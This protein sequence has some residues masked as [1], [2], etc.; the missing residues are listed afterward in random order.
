MVDTLSLP[1]GPE[2]LGTPTASLFTNVINLENFTL[3][4]TDPHPSI[5]HF[6]FSNLTT[7]NISAYPLDDEFHVSQLL[8]FLE[9][10]PAVQWVDMTF[11]S[12]SFHEDVPAERVI[13]L[14]RVETFRL[15][16]TSYG[17][18]QEIAAHIS[19]PSARHVNFD[20]SL[21][22]A[23]VPVPRNIYPSPDA[24]QAIVCQYTKARANQVILETTV[25]EHPEL[26]CLLTFRSPNKS[27]LRL[28]YNQFAIENEDDL[29]WVLD[30][31]LPHVFS[32]ASRV[33]R[34]Y[35]FLSRIEYLSI[36]GGKLTISHLGRA[37]QDVGNLLESMGRLKR[38]TL[39]GC[40]L[41]P[42]LDPFLDTPL[43]SD[44]I[45]SAS[46]PPIE[47]LVIINPT[48]SLCDD[49]ACTTAIVRLARSQRARGI[50]F[51]H[52]VLPPGIPSDVAE[53]LKKCSSPIEAEEF[54]D[55]TP[56]DKDGDRDDE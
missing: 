25:N 33:I 46:F 24:W 2:S 16:I 42:Y 30:T 49:E 54:D 17:T 43:F 15:G 4:I 55:R 31:Y 28:H 9:G 18:G 10:S 41:R 11:E 6:K 47:K 37:A 5:R 44:T 34:D 1:Y 35:P 7:L 14:P 8:D 52:V 50:P 26:H 12:Y 38:L 29:D 36:L 3:V 51:K 22:E 23:G 19:C 32:Q 53:A 56:L 40:D 39:D 45:Q 48:Q 13:V 27:T 21:F 20:R